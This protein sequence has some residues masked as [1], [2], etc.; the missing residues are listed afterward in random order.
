MFTSVTIR[1]KPVHEIYMYIYI[2]IKND[3][4][5]VKYKHVIILT[6]SHNKRVKYFL[7]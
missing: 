6:T 1:T 3:K 2:Y 4:H 5:V 7:V